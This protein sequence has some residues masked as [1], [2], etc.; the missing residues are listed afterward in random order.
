M[1]RYDQFVA[2]HLSLYYC[3]P[4][5]PLLQTL[6][7]AHGGPMFGPWHRL[8]LVLFE[9]A[10]RAVSGKRITVPYWD[11]TDPKS[12]GA[13]FKDTF[14]G[15]DG[16]PSD[17]FA[18]KSGPFR[19]DQWKLVVNP[20]G[21]L[22]SPSVT[23]YLTRHFGSFLPSLGYLCGPDGFVTPNLNADGGHNH[24][25]VHAWVGGIRG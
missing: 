4:Q 2:W 6:M 15:G 8:Y 14:M 23:T 24:N 22:A 19:K 7:R 9:N 5:D 13:V 10:L 16:D 11:W 1:T 3:T 12:T 21:F 25:A 20:P 17:D 18:V